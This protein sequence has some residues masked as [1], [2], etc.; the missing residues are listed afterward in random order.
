[1]FTPLVRSAFR[2]K[3]IY[4]QR[5][6]PERVHSRLDT[7]FGFEHH[8]I[9]ELKKMQFRVSVAFCVM[10]AIAIGWAKKERPELAG[11]LIKA[12]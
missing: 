1:M 8:A 6:A 11:S 5:T 10:L 12:G 3:D 7:S 9:R 2:W 4:D